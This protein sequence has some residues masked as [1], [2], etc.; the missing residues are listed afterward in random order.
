MADLTGLCSSKYRDHSVF[1]KAAFYLGL[2]DRLKA[3][4]DKGM[5]R[6]AENNA[7]DVL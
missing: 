6:T 2:M 7:D 1:L 4:E 3:N 5:M